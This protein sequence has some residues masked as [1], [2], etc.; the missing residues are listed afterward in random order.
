MSVDYLDTGNPDGTTFGQ[1][2]TTKLSFYGAA[3]IDQPASASQAAVTTTVGAALA[4]TAATTG[5]AIHG[6]TT[7]TQADG[8]VTRVNSLRVDVLAHNVLLTAI[9]AALVS[10]GLLKGS[11]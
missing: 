1:A 4:T 6:Y 5:A 7:N 8:I 10:Q 3:P 9:R 11:S 2:S